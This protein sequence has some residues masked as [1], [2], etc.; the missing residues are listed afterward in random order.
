MSSSDKANNHSQ[1]S[2]IQNYHNNH[3]DYRNGSQMSFYD[4]QQQQYNDDMQR[5]HY[6]PDRKQQQQQQLEQHSTSSD[7][8][9]KSEQ[10]M[11][12]IYHQQNGYLMKAS[13]NKQLANNNE[14]ETLNDD[15]LKRNSNKQQKAIN[16][17]GKILNS[18]RMEKSTKKDHRNGSRPIPMLPSPPSTPPPPLNAKIKDNH[19]SSNK[20]YQDYQ[21]NVH[22][23]NQHRFNGNVN[24][25]NEVT[26]AYISREHFHH[27]N[28]FAYI[29]NS[30]NTYTHTIKL[31]FNAVHSFFFFVHRWAKQIIITTMHMA[32]S[33][34][35]TDVHTLW[36][37][38]R[39]CTNNQQT[40]QLTV[41]LMRIPCTRI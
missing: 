32:L 41:A 18:S 4:N 13:S 14:C 3:M 23:S 20:F 24:N 9:S 27:L 34:I 39:H 2:M 37:H 10:Q 17:Y 35:Q 19:E 33:F 40:I 11:S 15:L 12:N 36:P 31:N 30:Y 25:N 26:L 16:Q 38:H 22:L 1:S 8:S 6:L 29:V 21:P 28:C 7:A 5:Q